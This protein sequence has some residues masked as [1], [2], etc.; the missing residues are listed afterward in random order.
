MREQTGEALLGARKKPR[1]IKKI[2]EDNL[3]MK[4]GTDLGNINDFEL[5]LQEK[6]KTTLEKIINFIIDDGEIQLINNEE[7]D[8]IVLEIK[9][10]NPGVLIGRHGHT[11]DALQYIVN[12]ITN[13]ETEEPER[14]KIIVDIEG[15]KEKREDIVS[16][17]ARE[18]AEIVKKTGKKTTLCYM[19]AVERRIV[20]LVLQEEPLLV[21]YS[22]GT[23]P[24]RKVIIAPKEN[25]NNTEE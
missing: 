13:K 23:E 18:K 22:E 14:R 9:T 25:E 6:A 11:L 2:K 4:E 20:H 8:T 15:Y 19:N 5:S 12:I 10:L 17:Y 1:N 3:N 16:K 7:D 21:T 24:F